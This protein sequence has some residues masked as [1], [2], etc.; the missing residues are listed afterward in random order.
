MGSVAQAWDLR[1]SKSLKAP[2]GRDKFDSRV[3]VVPGGLKRALRLCRPSGP[4][5]HFVVP[6]TR[7]CGG[8]RPGLFM[9]RP[10]GLRTRH[11]HRRRGPIDQLIAVASPPASGNCKSSPL[12]PRGRGAGGEGAGDEAASLAGVESCW[13]F[14]SIFVS[15]PMLSPSPPGAPGLG[16]GWGE[17]SCVSSAVSV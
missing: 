16:E 15:R 17:G 9:P 13:F 8:L 6:M 4:L 12:S 5:G 7:G 11:P 3:R 10:S 2:T 1:V 14:P